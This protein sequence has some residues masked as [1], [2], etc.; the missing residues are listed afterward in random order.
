M[1]SDID[2]LLTQFKY[3]KVDQLELIA[4]ID[5]ARCDL[6]KEGIPVSLSTIKHLIAT[7]EEWKAKLKKEHF[8][9]FSIQ[10]GIDESYKLFGE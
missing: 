4:T 7:N 6:E 1:L 5:M 3:T 9:D 10:R 2:W 8:D